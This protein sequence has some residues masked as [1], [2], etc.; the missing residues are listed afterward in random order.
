MGNVLN[1]ARREFADLLSNRLVVAILFVYVFIAVIGLYGQYV[2]TQGVSYSGFSVMN[3]LSY[4]MVFLTDY[5]SLVALAIGFFTISG[6]KR[7][8]TIDVLLVK[9]VYRDTVV[10]GKLLGALGFLLSLIIVSMI[11]YTMGLFL[12]YGDGFGSSLAGYL[13]G[14]PVVVLLSLVYVLVFFLV[15]MFLS[16]VIRDDIFALFVSVLVWFLLLDIIP[17]VLIAGNVSLIFTKGFT[18]QQHQISDFISLLSPASIRSKLFWGE[19][20]LL[21]SLSTNLFEVCKL[22]LYLFVATIASY[23]AFIRRDI[24]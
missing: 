8:H 6:E 10:N 13:E 9:P 24:S 3:Y 20:D 5:G 14:A 22:L 16:I 12:V 15:S 2:Y 17:N 21:S 1:V 19:T 18:V 11:L 7:S 23:I 4:L